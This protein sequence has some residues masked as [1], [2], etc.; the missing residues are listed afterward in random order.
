MKRYFLIF[1]NREIRQIK[2]TNINSSLVFYAA[3]LQ[4]QSTLSTIEFRKPPQNGYK[5]HIRAS[6][7]IGNEVSF[8]VIDNKKKKSPPNQITD[9]NETPIT[10]SIT[11]DDSTI[12][13]SFFNNDLL[14][15]LE[16]KTTFKED[17]EASF[18]KKVDVQLQA[19]NDS[20]MKTINQRF[21]SFQQVMLQTM[22]ELVINMIS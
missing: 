19:H 3:A 10:A 18:K 8:P 2:Q 17:I 14:E 7:D 13:S 11:N 4:K 12:V 1:T 21:T 16:K 15:I 5:H 9:S 20:M 22:K 6:Y